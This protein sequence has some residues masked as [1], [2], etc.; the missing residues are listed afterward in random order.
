MLRRKTLP[1]VEDTRHTRVPLSLSRGTWNRETWGKMGQY[2]HPAAG[3]VDIWP[4][5]VC[6]ARKALLANLP[7][8]SLRN[9]PKP[10]FLPSGPQG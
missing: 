8:P 6:T 10:C 2:V 7:S 1:L 3:V 5:S 4:V 9:C